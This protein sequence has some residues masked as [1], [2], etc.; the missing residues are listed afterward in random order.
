MNNFDTD[1]KIKQPKSGVVLGSIFIII[2]VILLLGFFF[3][4]RFI[5]MRFLWPLFVLVPGL[6]F[7]SAYFTERK[8]PGFLIPGGILVVIGLLFFFEVST[9]W[10]FSAYTWPVYIVA[11]AIG[12]YQYYIFGSKPKGILFVAILLTIVAFIAVCSIICRLV[13][14]IMPYK[15]IVPAI[16][17]IFGGYIIYYGM[18][19]NK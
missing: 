4:I 11:A 18:S 12:F 9:A 15:L 19:K 3:N 1:D 13:F 14:S 5:T 10:A 17:I 16:F 2:G 7:E 6:L 8:A